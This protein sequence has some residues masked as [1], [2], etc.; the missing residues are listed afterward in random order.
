VARPRAPP[1]RRRRWS[2][3]SRSPAAGLLN[4]KIG[5]PAVYPAAP[6]FLFLPPN[7]YGLKIWKEEKG[8]DRDSP[9]G[10]HAPLPLGALSDALELQTLNGD[11]ACV[12]LLP[13][14]HPAAGAHG[15]ER[16][17]VL[18]AARAL[19]LKT[20]REG[21]KSDAQRVE[22]AFRRVAARKAWR[23]RSGRFRSRCSK[24][25]RSASPAAA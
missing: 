17:D 6:E 4:P 13:F 9:G 15:A 18:E 24:N 2:A 14:E 20:L 23:R 10:V 5:G 16:T 25:R 11:V 1:P 7:S 21:G 3:T 12:R 22:F 19:A 8:E